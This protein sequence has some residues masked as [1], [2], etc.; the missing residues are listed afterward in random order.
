MY[1][2]IIKYTREVIGFLVLSCFCLMGYSQDKEE[3][4]EKIYILTNR[5][6]FIG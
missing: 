2:V 6:S 1:M 4:F 5:S 3:E